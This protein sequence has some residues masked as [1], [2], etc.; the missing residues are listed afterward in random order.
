M[1]PKSLDVRERALFATLFLLTLV[2]VLGPA[3][4]TPGGV[5]VHF[6]DARSWGALPNAMDVMS[7]LP[8]AVRSGVC[9]GCT[10]SIGRTSG[11]SA[12]KPAPGRR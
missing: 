4:A 11:R 2:A 6:A 3:V 7:N 8:F 1:S 12:C 10:G 9:T 5:A